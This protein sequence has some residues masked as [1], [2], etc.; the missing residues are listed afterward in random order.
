MGDPNPMS[1]SLP[2]G[3]R[4]YP[5]DK[6]LI[7]YYLSSKNS[8][9]HRNDFQFNLIREIDLYNFD[10][11]NLPDS[12]CFKYGRGSLKRHWFCFVA[13]VLKGGRRRAGGGY[14]KKRGRIRDVMGEGAGK[15]V[16]G[17]R[18]SFVFYLGDCIKTAVK[19]D[20]LMYEYALTGNPMASFVLCRVFIKSHY[21]N[22]LSEHVFSSYGEETLAAVRHVG[23]QCDGTAVSVTESKMHDE[24]TVDLEN[25]S[26]ALIEPV[27]KQQI[28]LESGGPPV[29]NGFSAQEL[30]AI[31]E[32]D[33]I[34]LDDL[35]C[36]LSGI[37]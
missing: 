16:V 31:L 29:L 26:Q 4:F 32:G 5:S 18:K 8:A 34:E 7:C 22:N 14:W 30:T 12:A 35:L 9:D 21:R 28:D 11:F 19:T 2:P 6:Q 20:L 17:T 24:N 15:V 23:I 25:D 13:R 1:F 36:P 27:A 10:P 37:N 33:F 3:T